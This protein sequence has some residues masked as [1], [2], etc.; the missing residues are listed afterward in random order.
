MSDGVL[1]TYVAEHPKMTG[2]LFTLLVL[3]AQTGTV[4]A[5]NGGY[6]GP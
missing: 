2:V 1:A 6:V 3:L 4:A 5:N